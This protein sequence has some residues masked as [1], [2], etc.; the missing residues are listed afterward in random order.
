MQSGGIFILV[1]FGVL[2]AAAIISNVTGK[3]KKEQPEDKQDKE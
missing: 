2:I 1:I 3:K